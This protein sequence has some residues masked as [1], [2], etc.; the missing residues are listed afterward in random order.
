MDQQTFHKGNRHVLKSH[1]IRRITKTL[2]FSILNY[3]L[4]YQQG[5]RCDTATND[6]ILRLSHNDS[7]AFMYFRLVNLLHKKFS[8][9]YTKES[10]M[11]FQIWNSDFHVLLSQ[12][13]TA[14]PCSVQRMKFVLHFGEEMFVLSLLLG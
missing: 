8:P 4:N 11:R 10:F 5:L 12:H 6:Y 14:R 7:L 9:Y 2:W 1:T 13:A 3:E